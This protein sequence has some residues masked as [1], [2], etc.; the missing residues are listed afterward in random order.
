MAAFGL[1]TLSLAAGGPAALAKSGGPPI[2]LCQISATDGVNVALGTNDIPAIKAYVS[3]INRH[4]GVLGRQYKLV[5]EN[6]SSTPSQ[7]ASLVTKCVVQDHANFILGPEETATMAAA[8]PVADSLHTVLITQGSGWDQGGVSTTQIHSYSFPGLYD[9]FYIDDLDT[10]K[11]LI[12]PEHLT[13]VAVIEDAVPGGLPNGDYMKSLC[14]T[15]HCSVVAVQNLQAGQTDDTPQVLNLLAAKP[16]IVVLGSIPGPDQITTIKAI[17]AENPSIPISECSVCWTPGFVQAAGGA[18]VLHNVYTRAPIPDLL[19]ALPNT[20]ANRPILSQLRTYEAAVTAAGY[21]TAQD[22][23]NLAPAWVEGQELTAAI[24]K[25]GST[26]ESKVKQALEHQNVETLDTFWNRSPSNY[27]GLK[28]VVDLTQTWNSSGQV[29]P[30]GQPGPEPMIGGEQLARI[31][32][33]L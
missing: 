2:T 4:G 10:A 13:R 21:G 23:D 33:G 24:K 25:A 26:D 5:E 11:R 3:Y 19:K 14:K 16:Q 18:T 8:V 6:D 27:S 31:A 28:E 9:V 30:V 20:A 15:Y 7:A 32:G 1:A 17:R 29:V 22:L 12:A